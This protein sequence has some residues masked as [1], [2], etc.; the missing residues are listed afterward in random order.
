MNV[1]PF[2]HETAADAPDT[3]RQHARE[4]SRHAVPYAAFWVRAHILKRLMAEEPM[5]AVVASRKESSRRH[6]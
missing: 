4:I 2:T 3:L 5:T 1:I 6:L